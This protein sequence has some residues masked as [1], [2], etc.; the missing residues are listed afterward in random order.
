MW[1][2]TPPFSQ[3]NPWEAMSRNSWLDKHIKLG[4]WGYVSH[5]LGTI[6][7]TFKNKED[8]AWFMMVWYGTNAV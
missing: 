1:Y 8:Y 4:T 3:Q 2:K 5:L 6:S 7:Y